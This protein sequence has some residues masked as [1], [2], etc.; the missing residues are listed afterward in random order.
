MRLRMLLVLS[1]IVIGGPTAFSHPLSAQEEKGAAHVARLLDVGWGTTTSF[2]TAADSQA[3]VLYSAAG[4]HP[5]ALYATALVQIKQR[6][7]AEA[8]KLMDEVLA[9]DEGN[10]PAWRAKVWLLT[11]LKNYEGAM[12]AADQ[13]SNLLPKDVAKTGE[14]DPER[15]YVAFLGR[16]YGFLGGPAQANVSIDARKDSEKAVTGRMTESRQVV[17]EE[18]RDGVLQKFVELSDAKENVKDKAK[19]QADA[20][21]EKVLTEIAELR[22]VNKEKVKE[23]EAK[24]EKGKKEHEK[25]SDYVRK[26]DAPLQTRLTELSTQAASVN[27]QLIN[28][29]SQI[30]LVQANLNAT[31]DQNVRN[32]LFLEL[33]RLSALEGTTQADLFNLNRQAAAV[34]QQRSTLAVRQQRADAD[35]ANKI[36][37]VDDELNVIAKKERRADIAQKRAA[38]AGATTPQ[39]ALSLSAQAG[40]LITY[41]PFPLEQEKSR[42]L[43]RLKR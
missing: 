13:L 28:I 22:D 19:E 43:A 14:E 33:N 30:V 12:V 6:R 2:R 8:V 4:R 10:L 35:L 20:E 27:M 9:R 42:L 25:E 40:A 18:A 11:V 36:S 29:D 15:A 38:K 37:Q 41:D 17:F 7:Y 1:L 39:S 24:I 3:E 31:K 21:R 34:Q 5:S 16:I 32:L 23:L 26:A